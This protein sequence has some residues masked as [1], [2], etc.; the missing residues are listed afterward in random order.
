MIKRTALS[1]PVLLAM[2]I[3]S[4]AVAVAAEKPKTYDRVSHSGKVIIGKPIDIGIDHNGVKLESVAFSGNEAL[5]IVWNRTPS[6]VKGNVGV[7]LFDKNN[8]LLAAESDAAS[9]TR[10][11]TSIR[12]GKQANLRVRFKKFMADFK[13][14]TRYRLVFVTVK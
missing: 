12:S 14:A 7:A 1:F 8:R 9:V 10:A 3:L 13:Q 4:M 2:S 5:V 6:A 11:I